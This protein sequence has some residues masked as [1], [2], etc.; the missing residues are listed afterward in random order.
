MRLLVPADSENGGFLQ[1]Y[2][3]SLCVFLFLSCL[4]YVLGKCYSGGDGI[5]PSCERYVVLKLESPLL[6]Q[7]C[8]RHTVLA[9]SKEA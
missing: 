5:V 4:V 7:S 8:D 3:I 1:G 6:L 2:I 9:L